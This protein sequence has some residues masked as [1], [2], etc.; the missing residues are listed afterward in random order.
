[1]ADIFQPAFIPL[2]ASYLSMQLLT[3]GTQLKSSADKKVP[4]IER[5]AL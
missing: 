2:D 3:Q 5:S 4:F 1:M